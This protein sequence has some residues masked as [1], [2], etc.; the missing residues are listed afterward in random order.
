MT[1]VIV[2][3]TALRWKSDEFPG[4][5]EVVVADGAGRSHHIIEKAAVLTSVEVTAASVFPGDLWLRAAYRRM[6]GDNVIV[7]FVDGVT[8]TEGLYELAVAAD[9]VR[10]L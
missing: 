5:I 4:W 2:R 8:T 9:D 7:H 10:W 1:D 6:D 3:S